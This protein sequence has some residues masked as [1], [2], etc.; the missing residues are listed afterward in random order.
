MTHAN[1]SSHFETMQKM[2][3]HQEKL[4]TISLDWSAASHDFIGQICTL[5]VD[6]NRSKMVQ[7]FSWRHA[8]IVP[9]SMCQL[10]LALARYPVAR[11]CLDGNMLGYRLRAA[12]IASKNAGQICYFPVQASTLHQISVCHNSLDR[13]QARE[14]IE[15]VY[16]TFAPARVAY[17]KR[18]GKEKEMTPLRIYMTECASVL[19]EA[20]MHELIGQVKSDLAL[21]AV[22]GDLYAA[23]SGAVTIEWKEPF[24]RF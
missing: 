10:L 21:H 11:V 8:G 13:L 7:F 6:A 1:G 18:A 22:H 20:T 3:L 14:F 24:R 5:C 12:R 16:M 19:T 9:N 23:S 17:Y 15:E 4:V 2:F